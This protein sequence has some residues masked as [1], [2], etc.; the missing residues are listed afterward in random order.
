[1]GSAKR[2]GNCSLSLHLPC[3]IMGFANHRWIILYLFIAMVII[4]LA[5]VIYVDNLVLTGSNRAH[6]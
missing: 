4:F 1:M 2:L 3:K 6:C 5:L